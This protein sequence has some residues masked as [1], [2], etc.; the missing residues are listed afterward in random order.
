MKFDEAKE[1][2]KLDWRHILATWPKSGFATEPVNGE[3][4]YIC[5][6]CKHGQNGDGIAL[7]KKPDGN[8]VILHCFACHFS[9]DVIKLYEEAEKVD[10]NQAFKAL[11]AMDNVTIDENG[12]K[13]DFSPNGGNYTTQAQER[14]PRPVKRGLAYIQTCVSERNRSEEA[15]EYLKRRGISDEVADALNIGYDPN[16]QSPAALENGKNPTPSKRMIIPF[17]NGDYTARAI[18]DS[19]KRYLNSGEVGLFNLKALYDE[20]NEDPVFITEGAFDALAI[21]EV[22]GQALALNSTSN[23]TL[24]INALKE[25][26]TTKT[27][28]L[29][30]D[31]DQ[32]GKKAANDLAGEL[33][34]L[35]T[36]FIIENVAGSCKDASEALV[37]NRAEFDRQVSIAKNQTSARPNRI[38]AYIDTQ[39]AED[40]TNFKANCRV[41]TG[42][43]NLDRASGGLF[44]GLYVIA[45]TT[46][47][48]KTTF[49][50]QLADNLAE[51]G[52]D[53]VYFSLEQSTYEIV[54]KSIARRMFLNG[55]K[56]FSLDLRCGKYPRDFDKFLNEYRQAVGDHLSVVEGNFNCNVEYIE[57]YLRHYI[58][59]TGV[60]PYVFVDY[61]QILQ[62]EDDRQTAKDKIDH[63]VTALKRLS[64]N[65]GLTIF[66]ISSV[67]RTNY[68]TPID[69]ESLKESGGIEYTADVVWGLQLEE[70]NSKEMA[71]PKVSISRKR[72]LMKIAKKAKPRQIELVCLKNR[73]GVSNFSCYFKYYSAFEYFENAGERV[74]NN[75]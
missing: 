16:W 54:S 66:I 18:D 39:M 26:P 74:G 68:L 62:P 53:V 4:S 23:K 75:N 11:A 51:A 24:L 15:K 48:G 64:R 35:D 43:D 33:K 17:A 3:K 38:T 29:A 13:N 50:L 52:K 19:G 44:Q 22:G 20:T 28:I 6:I 61:L 31:N 2:V 5:P 27:L 30:L 45:A 67:N 57:T 36:L 70:V 1:Q 32:A 14:P 8:K 59:K 25:K 42:F 9:G 7:S 73:N 55:K 60:R 37:K 46:S 56:V 10:F 21:I 47:L 58:T 49:A 41:P 69:F 65:L 71:D 12:P 63:T 40:A 72:E 34:S